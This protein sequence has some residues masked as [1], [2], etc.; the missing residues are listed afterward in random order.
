MTVHANPQQ[1]AGVKHDAGKLPYD[2]LPHEA[3]AEVVRVLGFGA[4]KYGSRN[5]EQGIRYGRMY[6]AAQ[7][8]LTSWW[9][10]ED[11]DME[12]GISHL[13]HAACDV[14]M[15]LQEQ[16]YIRN[17]GLDDRPEQLR[18]DVAEDRAPSENNASDDYYQPFEH[19]SPFF[20]SSPRILDFR[21]VALNQ[22]MLDRLM[23]DLFR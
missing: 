12:T 4:E 1:T 19:Q 18:L 5:W 3:I 23:K 22:D 2:L 10:R 14:L 11:E 21:P 15:L 9:M 20:Q 13:A 16:L 7:R 17:Q 8:H 6:A